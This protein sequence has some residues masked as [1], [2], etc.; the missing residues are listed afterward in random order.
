MPP[1]GGAGSPLPAPAPPVLPPAAGSALKAAPAR[2]QRMTAEQKA[3][4]AARAGIAQQLYEGWNVAVFGG[5]LP[6]DLP[7]VWNPRWCSVMEV[8]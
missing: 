1:T 7:I 3:F 4:I 8:L 2:R 5:K 6:P